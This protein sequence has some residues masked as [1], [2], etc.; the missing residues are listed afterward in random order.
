MQV[1]F[2]KQVKLPYHL[3]CGTILLRSLVIG[4]R[5]GQILILLNNWW[6]LVAEAVSYNLFICLSA[7]LF[8][9]KELGIYLVG[10][11]EIAQSLRDY[12]DN[13]FTL[14]TLNSMEYTRT[15]FDNQWQASR[16]VPCWSNF[17]PKEEQCRYLV[18]LAL[19]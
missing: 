14:S 18:I 12:F 17:I 11:S 13:L 19:I 10:C 16:K 8:Q 7:F 4:P 6:I 3:D 2:H 9:V 5:F 1:S 15:I